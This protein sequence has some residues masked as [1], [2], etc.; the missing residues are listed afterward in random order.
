MTDSFSGFGSGSGSGS[1]M[2]AESKGSAVSAFWGVDAALGAG[3]TIGSD[4]SARTSRISEGSGL[5]SVWIFTL[6][7]TGSLLSIGVAVSTVP[8][9][10]GGSYR[11]VSECA[12]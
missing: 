3:G 12:S 2:S 1:K 9:L 6:T 5:I 11:D 8:G 10:L 4:S 7:F